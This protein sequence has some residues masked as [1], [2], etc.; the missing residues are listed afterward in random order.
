MEIFGIAIT[1]FSLVIAVQTWQNGKFMKQEMK[2]TKELLAKKPIALVEKAVN[3]V[4][5]GACTAT[6][7]NNALC[8]ENGY[9]EVRTDKCTHCLACLNTNL[10]KGACVFR[11]YSTRRISLT[12]M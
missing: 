10:L 3:C 8:V 12:R 7:K 9:L 2:D 11:N 1:F 4:G 5:C 6:C